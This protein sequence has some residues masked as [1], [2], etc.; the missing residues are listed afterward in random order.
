MRSFLIFFM[1]LTAVLSVAMFP[2][3]IGWVLSGFTYSEC[4]H[5]IFNPDFRAQTDWQGWREYYYQLLNATN[6]TVP[7]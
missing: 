2:Q 7:N 3:G 1:F 5:S 6:A 4:P